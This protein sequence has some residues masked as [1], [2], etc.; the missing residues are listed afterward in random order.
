VVA[1]SEDRLA[2]KTND[3]KEA[4]YRFMSSWYELTMKKISETRC[5]QLTFKASC[6]GHQNVGVLNTIQK[7]LKRLSHTDYA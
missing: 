3:K 5:P 7:R 4:I 2:K 6:S 1:T